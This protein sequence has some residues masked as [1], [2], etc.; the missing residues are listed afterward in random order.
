[1]PAE[2]G[3]LTSPSELKA[4][5]AA[6]HRG[7]PFLVYRDGDGSQRIVELADSAA[8]LSIGRSP[9]AD[10]SLHWDPDVSRAHADL[11]RMGDVWTVVDD[12]ISRNGTYVNGERIRGRC[13]LGDGDHLRCGKTTITYR[14]PLEAGAVSTAVSAE[15]APVRV[16]TAQRRVLIALARPYAG[17]NAF[18]TPAT[19]GQIAEELFL[20]VAAV[21]TH[22]RA[23]C[24]RFG[25]EE[26]PQ[27]QKRA[28]L[29]ALAL[30]TG[31]ISDR[32]LTL[33]G[34]G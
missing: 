15:S 9:R 27:N 16:S 33:P 32:D 21:K 11:R 4:Q 23:L 12:G 14:N 28:R 5:L 30:E 18:A 20:S 34:D 6:A 22:L 17:G 13:R 7:N 29:V 24:Q 25:I 8:Q 2:L 3:H 1:M 31:Q 10:L 19:N 26:L